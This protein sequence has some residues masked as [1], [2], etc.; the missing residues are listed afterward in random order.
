MY[1]MKLPTLIFM[2]IVSGCASQVGLH[3]LPIV[4]ARVAGDIW[5]QGAAFPTNNTY[6]KTT[7]RQGD[8]ILATDAN[9]QNAEINSMSR[10]IRI[11]VPAVSNQASM[12][13]PVTNAMTKINANNPILFSEKAW[14]RGETVISDYTNTVFFSPSFAIIPTV[15]ITIKNDSMDTLRS[16]VITLVTNN[17]FKYKIIGSGGLVNE[18]LNVSWIAIVN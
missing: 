7:Y 6:L 5:T 14:Q 2:L 16:L 15:T 18:P 1:I 12:I 9:K 3:S 8:V 10:W 11:T 4:G 17:C 13:V